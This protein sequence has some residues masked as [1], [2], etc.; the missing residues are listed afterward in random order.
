MNYTYNLGG[1]S[2]GFIPDDI[3]KKIEEEET[4]IRKLV[5]TPNQ[6]NLTLTNRYNIEVDEKL[7]D[8]AK[9]AGQYGINFT[10]P[11]T[12]PDGTNEDA[13]IELGAIANQA[14]LLF[15]IPEPNKTFCGEIVY[16]AEKGE[17]NFL[18]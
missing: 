4:T 12:Y 15:E 7:T 3:S 16:K 5:E 17:Y 13:A 6:L 2:Y 14:S 10:L 9:Q 1:K 18:E 11:T 8:I